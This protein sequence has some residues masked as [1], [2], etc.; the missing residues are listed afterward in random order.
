MRS[1][2]SGPDKIERRQV[3][4]L[5]NHDCY[6]SWPLISHM[7]YSPGEF[8]RRINVQSRFSAT[9]P[10]GKVVV[11]K[12]NHDLEGSASITS[13]N[14]CRAQSDGKKPVQVILQSLAVWGCSLFA[15]GIWYRDR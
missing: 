7:K 11:L 14:A 15:S 4:N 13:T 9:S 2:T 8:G 6:H 10:V 12:V 3:N 5:K 1:A